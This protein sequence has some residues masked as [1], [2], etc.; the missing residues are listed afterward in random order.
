MLKATAPPLLQLAGRLG[1]D[2]VLGRLRQVR[3][4]RRVRPGAG[5]VLDPAAA[6]RLWRGLQTLALRVEKQNNNAV[7]IA[8]RLEAHPAVSAVHHCSLTSHPDHEVAT[9]LMR[10]M[11]GVVSFELRGGGAD[12]TRLAN[13][14]THFERAPSLG[15]VSSLVTWP[16]GV[17]HVGLSAE[18]RARS[19]VRAGLIRLALGTE[20]A[21]MLWADLQQALNGLA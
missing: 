11:G 8:S 13:A 18:A 14:L 6:Y 20:D 7:Q 10:G 21:D 1:A 17:S 4:L 12:A 19:G 15:G 16:A 5:P 2:R 3:A 9:R